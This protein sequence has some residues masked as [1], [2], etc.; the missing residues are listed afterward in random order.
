I[1]H[2]IFLSFPT[3]RSSDLIVLFIYLI[4]AVIFYY[5]SEKGMESTLVFQDVIPVLVSYMLGFL[6]LGT[7]KR[8]VRYTS[9][10]DLFGVFKACLLGFSFLFLYLLIRPYEQKT[11]LFFLFFIHSG[12]T[13]LCLSFLRI[14]YKQFYKNYVMYGKHK[15]RAL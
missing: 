11:G 9:F 14:V 13:L 5:N 3:R 4:C 1:S 10:K 7:H 6:L 15:N 8:V 2:C 12:S